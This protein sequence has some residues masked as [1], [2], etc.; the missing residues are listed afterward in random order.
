[1]FSD[2]PEGADEETVR[3]YARAYIMMLLSTELFGG[4]SG[5]RMHIRWLPYVARLEDIDSYSWGSAA[6]S[7]LYRCLCRVAN[8]NV[9]KL[10][11]PLQLLQ[12]WIFRRF[13]GFRPDRF[14][15]F[16]WLLASRWSD[17][18]PTSSEKGP[19]VVHC[20]MRIDLLRP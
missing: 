8:K 9:V 12:S 14:D 2:L 6:R 13:P 18:Q 10:A 19:Q 1:M 11:G 3:R 15:A 5:T 17:Y 7:W 16:H 20:R 4:K